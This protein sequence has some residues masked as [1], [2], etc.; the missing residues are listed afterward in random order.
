MS[1]PHENGV[2]GDS[3]GAAVVGSI[4]AILETYQQGDGSVRLPAR[5]APY[6]GGQDT[7]RKRN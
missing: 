4:A 1:G 3:L 2:L 6:M 5:L 7:I